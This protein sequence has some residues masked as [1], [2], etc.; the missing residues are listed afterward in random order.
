[1]KRRIFLSLL[2]VGVLPVFLTALIVMLSLGG[3]LN[4]QVLDELKLE[5]DIVA[6][7]F[8]AGLEEAELSRVLDE[9]SELGILLTSREGEILFDTRFGA[10]LGALSYETRLEDGSTLRISSDN[11]EMSRIYLGAAVLVLAVSAAM[12]LAA[13]LLARLLTRRIIEPVTDLAVELERLEPDTAKSIYPEFRPMLDAI[14]FRQSEIKRQLERVKKEKNRIATIINTM[15][16]GLVILGSDMRVIMLNDA[17]ARLMRTNYP[18]EKCVGLLASEVCSK[19][20]IIGCLER[21]ERLRFDF[22]GR[23]LTM[24][25]KNI[26]S[27]SENVGRIGLILD[28]TERTEIERIKQE[29]T[30]NISHE[31]KTPL[32]SISGY[33]ELISTGMARGDDAVEFSGRIVRESAR[34]LTLISDIIKLSKLDT[35]SREGFEPV[36]LRAVTLESFDVLSDSAEKAGVELLFEGSELT[37]EGSRNEL[38]ELVYNLIDNAIRYNRRGGRLTVC[39]SPSE[40]TLTVS[41]TG[42]GIPEEH[43]TRVFER[44]YR[45]DKSRSKATGGTGLGLA[46]VKHIA[47]RYGARLELRSRLGEGT[48]ITVRFNV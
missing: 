13:T 17:A 45:V 12:I 15:D 29:F 43:L 31:L 38:S 32:T 1:M 18:R 25:V 9:H 48:V 14:V 4:R 36:E 37:V 35:V 26:V 8:T 42:I 39:V 21:A 40:R 6:A 5:G 10:S 23:H 44:F 30:A 33:A 24:Q 3:I 28:V 19:P 11:R 34:L 7:A 16:E 20:E 47:E 22:E 27:S 2:A 41:D 46:I